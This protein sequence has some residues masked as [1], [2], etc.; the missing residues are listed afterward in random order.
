MEIEKA[1]EI[2]R[3]VFGEVNKMGVPLHKKIA[4]A[5]QCLGGDIAELLATADKMASV[6]DALLSQEEFDHVLRSKW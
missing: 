4:E 1:K 6:S 2:L 5:Y 3:E